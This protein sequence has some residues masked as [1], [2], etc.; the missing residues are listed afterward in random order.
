MS[1]ECR[2][3]G[4]PP[5]AIKWYHDDEEVTDGRR[6][7]VALPGGVLRLTIDD[8]CKADEGA[9]KCKAENQEG[10]ASTTGYMSVKGEPLP[11]HVGQR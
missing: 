4:C 8:V 3:S 7:L 6:R 2:W 11:L 9:Y 10:V 1:F 5:P